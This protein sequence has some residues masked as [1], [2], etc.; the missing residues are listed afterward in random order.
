LATYASAVHP[1]TIVPLAGLGNPSQVLAIDEKA[2]V[3]FADMVEMEVPRGRR[4]LVAVL[5]VV[6]A[7]TGAWVWIRSAASVPLAP[8]AVL[9][10]RPR[11]GKHVVMTAHE[12]RSLNRHSGIYAATNRSPF[13]FFAPDSVWNRPVPASA[14][15][16]PRS[17]DLIGAFDA[18]IVQEERTKDSPSI[19]T[20]AYSVPIYTVPADQPTVRVTLRSEPDHV[21][22]PAL[23][24]AWS[25]VPLPSNA[26]PAAGG[27][28]HLVVS[29]PSTDRLWEFWHLEQT[30][31][32]WQAGWG[33]AIQN[34]SSDSGAYGP[35]AWPGAQP[36]WGAS[37]SSL[38]IAG[39][40]ITLED[41][42]LGQ[43]NHA[44]AMAIPNVRAGVYASPAQRSDG[45]STELLSLPEGAHLRLNPRLN[46]SALHLPRLTLMM[47]RAAQRYGIVIR[48]KGAEV[49]FYAQDPI[50]TGTEPYVG[51]DGYFEGKTPQELLAFFPWGY[52]QVL[53]MTLRRD[54]RRA[55]GKV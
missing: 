31:T 17:A 47:A 6:L 48:D 12:Q 1:D 9:G 22:Q 50:P 2:W 38:S 52:L 45:K 36:G 10:G 25:A 16:A 39:G 27:D 53:R 14:R 5:V 19:N 54:R 34:V 40:L 7:V 43:I 33:G 29:Q 37:G 51:T 55:A 21:F 42:E 24:A 23:Q 8:T 18:E 20:M 32:G 13:R 41:L 15:L 44:L 26:Q 49:A 3:G 11:P 28:K 46:L 35:E 30:L 4:L